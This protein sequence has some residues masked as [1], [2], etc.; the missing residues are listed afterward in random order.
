MCTICSDFIKRYSERLMGGCLAHNNSRPRYLPWGAAPM[1]L[2][3][4]PFLTYISQNHFLLLTTQR[5]LTEKIYKTT[6]WKYHKIP[7]PLSGWM[8]WGFFFPLNLYAFSQVSTMN[9]DCFR[10]KY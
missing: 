3:Q 6:A 7:L 5:L 4:A 2:Q 9:T 1:T 10:G 8:M